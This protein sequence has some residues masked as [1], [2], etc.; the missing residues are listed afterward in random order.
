MIK[1]DEI[2]DP[3]S[4]LNR[5]SDDEPIFVLRA[6]DKIAPYV[7]RQWASAY[8][9]GKVREWASACM[10]G[11]IEYGGPLTERE[12]TKY[13]QACDLAVQMEDWQR[14]NGIIK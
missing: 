5:A 13:N 9:L 1:R 14:A 10:L 2:S 4:C 3:Y 11:K 6:H 12:T 8:V 7:V